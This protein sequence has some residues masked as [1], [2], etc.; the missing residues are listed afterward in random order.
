MGGV[1]FLLP[2]TVRIRVNPGTGSFI[3]VHR[4]SFEMV[5]YK[6]SVSQRHSQLCG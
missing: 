3:L 4:V 6:I 5:E 1:A 2:I